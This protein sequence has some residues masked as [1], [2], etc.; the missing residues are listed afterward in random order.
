M[1]ILWL[2][3]TGRVGARRVEYVSKQ[4]LRNANHQMSASVEKV[5]TH[6][7]LNRQPRAV[8]LISGGLDS[9]LA[10]RAVIEQGVLVEGLNFYTGFW[11]EGHTHAIRKKDQRLDRINLYPRKHRGCVFVLRRSCG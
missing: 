9:L 10:A 7:G 1:S 5:T 3:E 2:P 4:G 6:P 11:V 8:A